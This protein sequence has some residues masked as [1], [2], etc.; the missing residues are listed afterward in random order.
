MKITSW[1]SYILVAIAP[2]AAYDAPV[3]PT[4]LEI[5]TTFKPESCPYQA[6]KKDHIHVHYV[7]RLGDPSY[8]I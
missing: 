3:A 8:L 1:L 2:A 7:S 6:K 5:E 4:E